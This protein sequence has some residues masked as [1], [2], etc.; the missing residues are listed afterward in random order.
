MFG[1]MPQS[2][3]FHNLNRQSLFLADGTEYTYFTLP[4]DYPLEQ[5]TP[6]GSPSAGEN[7]GVTDRLSIGAQAACLAPVLSSKA[8]NTPG[9]V[10]LLVPNLQPNVQDAPHVFKEMHVYNIYEEQ[11]CACLN[12][13]SDVR[14]FN[15]ELLQHDDERACNC[16]V[17]KASESFATSSSQLNTEHSRRDLRLLWDPGASA[18]LVTPQ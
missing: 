10:S 15:L 14:D 1:E 12:I 2:Y 18:F 7:V 17:L 13:T 5:A 8:N 3:G 4:A 11:D 9:S 6:P 16:P